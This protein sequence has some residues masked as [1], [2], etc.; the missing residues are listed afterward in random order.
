MIEVTILFDLILKLNHHP[1][2]FVPRVVTVSFIYLE[3]GLFFPQAVVNQFLQPSLH[4]A[5]YSESQLFKLLGL[6]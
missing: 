6:L 2:S 3:P 4:T 5:Q 1:L